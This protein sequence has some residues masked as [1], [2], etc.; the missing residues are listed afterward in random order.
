MKNNY[1]R[2][3]IKIKGDKY[4]FDIQ[5]T[6]LQKAKEFLQ[7]KVDNSDH[8][9][10]IGKILLSSLTG[11]NSE[12]KI[13]PEDY[14]NFCKYSS[15]FDNTKQVQSMRKKQAEI[16]KEQIEKAA[17]IGNSLLFEIYLTQILAVKYLFDL[18]EYNEFKFIE[19][20]KEFRKLIF[21][22]F[23]YD[24]PEDFKDVLLTFRKNREFLNDLNSDLK[25][26]LVFYN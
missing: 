19:E 26:S 3:K 7:N 5:K 15:Y 16:S 23:T 8:M 13:T 20:N 22:E 14:E 2:L 21:P 4:I 6:D 1:E 11:S 24:I 25:M 12:I 10:S 9:K 17:N 18:E